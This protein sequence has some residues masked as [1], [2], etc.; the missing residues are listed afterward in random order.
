MTSQ[1]IL[2]AFG[3]IS[4]LGL[5]ACGNATSDDPNVYFPP[6][7]EELEGCSMESLANESG[8]KVLCDGDSVATLLNGKDGSDGKDGKS[9]TAEP[10]QNK[11]GLKILCG[12]DSVGVV[13]NGRDGKDGKDGAG[14]SI[15]KID[16]INARIICGSD[17]ITFYVGRSDKIPVSIDSLA[18]FAQKGPF[19]KGSSV[20][21]YELTDGKT[22]KQTKGN[23]ITT[24]ESDDGRFKFSDIDL[25]C[26]YAM[27]LADG[28]YKNEITGKGTVSTIKLKSL[29]DISKDRTANINLMTHLEYDRIQYL[30]TQKKMS[31]DS[32][33]AI[34]QSEIFKTF[35]I[36]A[37]KFDKSEKLDVTGKTDADAA[38]LAVSVLLQ[39]ERNESD[40]SILLTDFST[41]FREDGKWNDAKKLATIADW[42]RDFDATDTTLMKSNATFAKIIRQYWSIENGLGACGSDSIPKGTVKRVTNSDSRFYAKTY[43]D[44]AKSKERFTCVG[45]SKWRLATNVEKDTLEWKPKNSKDGAILTGPIS[46]SKYVF[47]KDTIRQATKEEIKWNKGCVS[48]LKNESVLLENQ[49][50]YYKC[51]NDGWAFDFE[52]LN[53]GTLTDKRD[54]KT[55]KTVGIKSQMWMAENLNYDYKIDSLSYGNYC[56]DNVPENCDKF[57]RIYLWSAAMDTAKTECG[58]M[59]KCSPKYPA[60]GIC[61]DGWHL[62]DNSEFNTLI[63]AVGGAENAVTALK[64]TEGWANNHEGNSSNGTNL[65]GFNASPDGYLEEN[66]IFISDGIIV[67]YWS[68]TEDGVYYGHVLEFHHYTQIAKVGIELKDRGNYIR[69]VKD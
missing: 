66:G 62:P 50:S 45:D 38:L 12:E 57:G 26:Q 63:E 15:T 68:P 64:S 43:A 14:C 39:G 3:I 65:Y 36:D 21:L 7:D 54:G 52:H 8:V 49:Y 69:C 22:L 30:V 48:Y 33:K 6:E 35:H 2:A 17:S 28:R 20:Y 4:S 44:T 55:Y 10:L 9:C 60:Q 40:L 32:A 11:T 51:T 37:E 16:E 42:A 58:W 41:D 34:A 24:I 23:Y 46:G 67:N 47:D 56:F 29:I 59:H 61:P 31:V 53:F 25:E 18:G 27:L 1:R 5:F 19:Q 13:Y